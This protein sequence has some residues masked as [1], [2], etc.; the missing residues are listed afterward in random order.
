LAEVAEASGGRILPLANVPLQDV[1]L[2]VQETR[3]IAEDLHFRGIALGSNAA[4]T[5]LGDD[6]LLPFWPW[7]LLH[8]PWEACSSGC[9]R[10]TRPT[11]GRRLV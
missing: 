6:Q 1:A 11:P 3:R 10:S 4:G 5:N 8:G 9:P 2:A 7:R